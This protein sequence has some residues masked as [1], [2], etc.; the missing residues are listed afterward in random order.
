VYIVYLVTGTGR[1]FDRHDRGE[2]REVRQEDV[3]LAP[4]D[5][6]LLSGEGG[7]QACFGTYKTVGTLKVQIW[8]SSI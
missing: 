3:Y 6:L 5:Q 1:E 4:D 2:Q 8:S 7:N